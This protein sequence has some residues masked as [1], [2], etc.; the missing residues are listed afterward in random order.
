M[1]PRNTAP[2]T[3]LK[4]ADLH[5]IPVLWKT[6][7]GLVIQRR[8][9]RVDAWVRK[10]TEEIKKTHS[11]AGWKDSALFR[12]YVAMHDRFS[13]H[14]GIPSSCEGLIDFI[15]ARG[16]VPKINTFVDTYNTI[17]AATGVSIGAHDADKLAGAPRLEILQRDLSFVPIGGRGTG[18]ARQGEF[19]YLD[20]E[21]V[22]CRM[23]IRQCDRTKITEATT[24]VFVIFQGHESMDTALLQRCIEMLDTSAIF[25][26]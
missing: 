17:S 12:G 24:R 9:S 21:G 25:S 20:D 2:I 19:A 15:F 11:D 23:D 26:P 8:N 13:E 14:K 4:S 1:T 6:Y 16:S 5:S 3:L 22:I 10:G 18:T 7:E